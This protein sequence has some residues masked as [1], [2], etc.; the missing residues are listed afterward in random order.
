MFKLWCERGVRDVD[1]CL[2]MS[3]DF[4][5]NFGFVVEEIVELG[6]LKKLDVSTPDTRRVIEVGAL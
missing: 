4:N 2:E 6:V 5:C 1:L 3:S